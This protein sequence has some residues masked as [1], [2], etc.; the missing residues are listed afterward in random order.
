MLEYFRRHQGVYPY[1]MQELYA[2]C[3]IS[4]QGHYGALQ[5]IEDWQQKEE[6]MVRLILEIR[7]IHPGMGLRTMYEFYAPEGIG[8]DAFISIG[9]RYGFRVKAFRNE[10]RTT[11]SSPYYRYPN[12]L[13][14]I[15]IQGINRIWTSDLTYFRIGDRF[16]YIVFIMDVYSRLIVGYSV[17]EHMRAENNVKALKMAFRKRKTSTFAHKLIHHSDR[18][19]QYVSD[20][21][22]QALDK[23][24]IRISM[25]QLVYENAH[26]ERVNGTIKNQ[27]L[28]HWNITTFPQLQK[29]LKRAVDAYNQQKPHSALEKKTPEA[30]EQYVNQMEEKDRPRMRIWTENTLEQA[31]PNQC[32]IQF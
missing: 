4:K 27:Y 8:R 6:L 15:A 3:G 20:L 18:G 13:G 12:L 28:M 16:A 17:A 14:D 19:G 2:H 9:L 21:Y 7:E 24:K 11:F 5:R 10:A 1:R 32:I 31:N 25:C 26:V 23:A 30:F 22:T 29:Q